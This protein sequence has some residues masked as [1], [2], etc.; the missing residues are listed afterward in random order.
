MRHRK[1]QVL[2]PFGVRRIG[3]WEEQGGGS[4]GMRG[5]GVEGAAA[6]P[7]MDMITQGTNC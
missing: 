6:G 2:K 3:T 1:E 7:A 4:G 5:R